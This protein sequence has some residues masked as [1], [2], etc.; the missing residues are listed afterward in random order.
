MHSGTQWF[1]MNEQGVLQNLAM[2]EWESHFTQEYGWPMYAEYRHAI[3]P[4]AGNLTNAERL[5]SASDF[6]RP[7]LAHVG[8]PASGELPTTKGFVTVTPAAVQLSALRR[9]PAGGTEIRVVEV[10]VR[11]V[12]GQSRSGLS[13]FGCL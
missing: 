1:R 12:A 6:C 3:Q 7:L 4:H 13:D 11:P 8:P 5:A 2:R 10:E 9:K